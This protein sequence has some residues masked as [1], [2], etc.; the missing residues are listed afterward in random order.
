MQISPPKT[1]SFGCIE[2]PPRSSPPIVYPPTAM[3]PP[4]PSVHFDDVSQTPKAALEP[5]ND[6]FTPLV[7]ELLGCD[8]INAGN[9]ATRVAQDAQSDHGKKEGTEDDREDDD[10]D[11]SLSPAVAMKLFIDERRETLMRLPAVL[12]AKRH[13]LRTLCDELRT[14]YAKHSSEQAGLFKAQVSRDWLER[15]LHHVCKVPTSSASHNSGPPMLHLVTEWDTT[16]AAAMLHLAHLQSCAGM[17]KAKGSGCCDQLQAMHQQASER[18]AEAARVTAQRWHQLRLTALKDHSPLEEN[19]KL[20]EEA[21]KLEQANTARRMALHDVRKVS[22]IV[23]L[24]QQL[25]QQ[26]SVTATLQRHLN[27]ATIHSQKLLAEL[28]TILHS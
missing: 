8:S 7:Q 23:M 2:R 24:K 12:S 11:L 25:R 16:R 26:Q 13:E 28:Q 9:A 4:R 20:A 14:K 17:E 21:A 3:L 5:K 6:R 1:K 18:F 19:N 27:E 22:E 10:D 15:Q